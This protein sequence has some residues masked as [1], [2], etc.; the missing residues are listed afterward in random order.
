MVLVPV[1]PIYLSDKAKKIGV[2]TK[3]I[4]LADEVNRY[5]YKDYVSKASELI[6][7]LVGKRIMIVGIAYKP[8][9]SDVRESPAIELIKE[10]RGLGAEVNWHD[11]LVK[12]WRGTLSSPI[13]N[14][15]DLI[16]VNSLHDYLDLSKFSDVPILSAKNF[17]L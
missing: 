5:V 17:H 14:N 2:S 7:E 6:G 16:I 9:V 13:N 10:L 15:C 8:N 11:D 3:F 12:V 4:D 1:D